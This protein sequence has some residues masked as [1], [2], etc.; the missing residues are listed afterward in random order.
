[1]SNIAPAISRNQAEKNDKSGKILLELP[2][3]RS[4]I[5]YACYTNDYKQLSPQVNIASF[6]YRVIIVY[7]SLRSLMILSGRRSFH[8]I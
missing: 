1:M 5:I 7:N 8:M 4:F 6:L 2:R 3:E